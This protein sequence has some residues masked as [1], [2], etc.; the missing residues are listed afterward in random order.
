VVVDARLRPEDGYA[1]TAS[2]RGIAALIPLLAAKTTTWGVPAD[3]SH[4]FQRLT[5]YEAVHTGGVPDTP[6]GKRKSDLAPRPFMLNPTRCGVPREVRITATSYPLPERPSQASAALPAVNGCGALDFD[7]SISFSPTARAADSPAGMDVELSLGQAGIEN[8][9]LPATAHLKRTV[10]AL[11]QGLALNPAAASGLGACTTEQIGLLAKDP[12]RF[13]SAPSACPQSSRVGTAR[14]QTPLLEEPLRGSLYLAAQ[15]DNPFDA[16]LAGYLAVEGQGVRIKLA[17]RFEV[18]PGGRIEATFDDN[19]QAPFERATLHFKEGARGVLITPPACGSYAI[20]S[21]LSPWSA[22][23][24]FHPSAAERAERDSAFAIET[25]PSG[26]L[27]PAGRFEPALEAWTTRPEAARYSPFVLRVRREDGSRRLAALNLALP[28][29]LSAKLAGVRYCPEGALAAAKTRDG[30]G[31]GAVELAAPSCPPASRIGTAIAGAGAGPAPFYLRTG[32]A[33]LAGPYRGAPLS[34]AVIA[35]ALAG[36]FDL[37][38]VLVRSAL[39]ID[40]R[41]ARASAASDPLPSELHDIPLALRD[42][43]VLLDRP[44]F[45]LNPTSCAEKRVAATLSSEQGHTATATSRFQVGGCRGLGFRP[46]LSLRLFG[47][48]NRGAHPRLRAVLRPRRGQANLRRASVAL[49]R[50]EFLDQSHIRTVCTRVQFAADR[51]PR[52]SVY[53]RA[54]AF[55]PL[56]DEPLRGPVYLRSSSHKL[57]DLVLALRGQ[58]EVEAVGRI[59]SKRG[60]IRTTFTRVPDVPVSKVVLNM[61]GAR[62]GLLVNSRDLCRARARATARLAAHNGRRRTLRPRVAAKCR[63]G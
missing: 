8:P 63:R 30:L 54:V 49:P 53:G 31:Q 45:A 17:G 4:D 16:L 35:P 2:V 55:S 34:V 7:P 11:P 41:A 44:R 38:T 61:R 58:V 9:E 25:G 40:P 29:G 43:R 27:C 33:Y 3:P 48:T 14:I 20:R 10:V 23:D 32:R 1:A 28:A 36:P 37:G 18:H 13:D 15:R 39:R 12:P 21:E 19:P 22:A 6:D 5:P 47:P 50:S 52:G 56:L 60:G 42:V 26:G 46:R 51:C 62:K 24:P 59:D 57:P